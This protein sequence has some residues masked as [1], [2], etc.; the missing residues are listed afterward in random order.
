MLILLIVLGL[1]ALPLLFW[2]ACRFRNGQKYKIRSE[3]G[4]QS[5]EYIR[6]GGIEQYIQM[7]GQ[8]TANPIV[9]LLHGGPGNDMAYNSYYWQA[10]LEKHYT[11]VNWDQRGCGN[12]Y[13]RKPDT[14]KPTL[15]L[16][17]SDLDEL[18]DSLCARFG[19][20]NVVI[21]GHSWGTYL[22]KI[23]VTQHP[24]KVSAYVGVG[25]MG[26][27]WPSEEYAL[28]EAVRL[29]GSAG[30]AKDAQKMQEQ[31]A[32]VMATKEINMREFM[33]LRQL[34]GKYL[35]TGKNT[36]LSASLLSPHLTYHELKWFLSLLFRLDRFI[37]IQGAL[38]GALFAKDTSA[39][40]CKQFAVPVF[41]LAGDCDW[42]TPHDMARR[43]FDCITAPKKEFITLEKAGHIPFGQEQFTKALANVLGQVPKV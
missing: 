18:V 37:A 17:L 25:Q 4:I 27:P 34:T 11:F 10:D 33:K 28:E 5:A 1:L 15:P 32:R 23:Y 7:R 2:A 19:Q 14:E 13:Y 8:D 21:L 12:T 29:A 20:K 31:F 30:K 39:Y 16:L 24:E 22:G 40:E 38:Y 42:I 3:S 6:L 36:P 43:Y 26:N 9:I 35:P 41:I